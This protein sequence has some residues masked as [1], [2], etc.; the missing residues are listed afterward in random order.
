MLI[1]PWATSVGHQ[2]TSW[3]KLG[4][5]FAQPNNYYV[6]GFLESWI[7]TVPIN[8]PTYSNNNLD[9]LHVTTVMML[10]YPN[11]K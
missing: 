10:S 5:F 4:T 8:L 11:C 9:L 7:L 6:H 2:S 1:L 3:C